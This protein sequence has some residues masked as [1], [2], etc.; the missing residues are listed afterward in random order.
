MIEKLDIVGGQFGWSIHP[1]IFTQRCWERAPD[2]P[3]L[4][5]T[6]RRSGDS[7]VD[8]HSTQDRPALA[9]LSSSQ[10]ALIGVNTSSTMTALT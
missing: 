10:G 3:P 5:T 1:S 2:M 8:E 7:G 4:D 6:A 9:Q